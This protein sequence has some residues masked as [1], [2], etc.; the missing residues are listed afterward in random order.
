MMRGVIFDLKR[1]S[2]H[3]GPGIRTTLFLKGCPLACL[4]CHNP[5]S[6]RRAPQIMLRPSRCIACG[7]CVEKCPQ[8]AITWNGAGPRTDTALCIECGT[9]TAVCVAEAREV[10][11]REVEA[12]ALL[13][14]LLRDRAFFDES[15]GGVTFSGGEPLMQPAFL[16]AL[17]Q[18][19]RAEEVHTAVD[20]SGAVPWR[21]LEQVRPFVDLFLY[22]LKLMDETRHKVATGASNRLILENLRRLAATGAAIQ[23]RVA[24]IPGQNDDEDNLRATA[25]FA[26]ALPGVRGLS[27]LPYHAAAR[28]KYGRLGLPYSLAE[29]AA[30]SETALDD[31]EKILSASGLP[32]TR[33][34]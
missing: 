15:G 4:W 3:D 5:E 9:C 24:L 21:S 19:C 32:V 2:V 16:L 30:P 31:A 25:A 27:L 8:G 7:A 10:I 29:T 11:G 34:G 12:Q 13:P 23:L 6:Q 20:T 14:D 28:D 22:D 33:G 1:F 18:G 17:L 26:A